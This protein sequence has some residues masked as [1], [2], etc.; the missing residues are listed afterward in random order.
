MIKVQNK[1]DIYSK[2]KQ[3]QGIVEEYR[4]IAWACRNADGKVKAQLELKLESN[5]KDTKKSFCTRRTVKEPAR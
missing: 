1:K 4:N 2:S 5:V 3:R